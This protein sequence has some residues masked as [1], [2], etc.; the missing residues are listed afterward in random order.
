M[1]SKPAL[2]NGKASP[3]PP[4][5]ILSQESIQ[6]RILDFEQPQGR[7]KKKK[8]LRLMCKGQLRLGEK[9]T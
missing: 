3:C 2:R 6:A 1:K 8:S 9:R 7:K 4:E 5:K